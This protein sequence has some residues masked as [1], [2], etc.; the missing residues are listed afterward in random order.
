MKLFYTLR[1]EFGEDKEQLICRYL[2]AR[3]YNLEETRK[4]ITKYL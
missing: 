3:E 1:K 4:S 2:I